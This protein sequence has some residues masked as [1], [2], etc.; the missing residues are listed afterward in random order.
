MVEHEFEMVDLEAEDQISSMQQM[1]RYKYYH[2]K[3]I[4]VNMARARYI[5]SFLE[6][7]NSEV[8]AK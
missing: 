2:I 1:I 7:E 3:E 6:Q 8:K 5:I 4:T